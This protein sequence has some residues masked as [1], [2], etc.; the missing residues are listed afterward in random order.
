M[1]FAVPMW[2]SNSLLPLQL[3][4]IITRR[5]LK[6]FN[7]EHGIT[8]HSVKRAI[9]ESAYLF[10]S[11]G[12]NFRSPGTGGGASITSAQ[13]GTSP[14]ATAD[15]IAELT[16]DMLEAADNLEFERA[17]YLRDQIKELKKRK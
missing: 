3:S 2:L 10:K 15:L 16:R 11:G 13:A 1:R 12:A 8:P 5:L 7:K 14:R 4:I 17:A 6:V 9:N